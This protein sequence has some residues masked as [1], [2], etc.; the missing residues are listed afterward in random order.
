[1][2]RGQICQATIIGYLSPGGP[3]VGLAD[4]IAVTIMD[5]KRTVVGV[6]EFCHQS[7]IA[8]EPE[9]NTVLAPVRHHHSTLPRGMWECPKTHL[10]H[11]PASYWENGERVFECVDCYRILS[12]YQYRDN[13]T[14]DEYDIFLSETLIEEEP[15]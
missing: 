7:I 11:M 10:D 6:C 2:S 3:H 1:M 5:G 15:V 14:G 9:Y 8:Q 4:R 12:A 13:L